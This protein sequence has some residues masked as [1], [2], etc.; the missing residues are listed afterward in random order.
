[1]GITKTSANDVIIHLND[2]I[3]NLKF[4]ERF[5]LRNIIITPVYL[6][7]DLSEKKD[8]LSLD[9]S[10]E[11]KYS[12]KIRDI[13]DI[14]KIEIEN[15]T[16]RN[17]FIMDG[18]QLTGGLQNRMFVHSF[19]LEPRKRNNYN[20]YCIESGRWGGNTRVF[21][22]QRDLSYTRVRLL[23]LINTRTIKKSAQN[24]IWKEIER[25][26]QTLNYYSRTSSLTDLNRYMDKVVEDYIENYEY[27]NENGYLVQHEDNIVSFEILNE[28]SLVKKLYKKMLKS[29]IYDAIGIEEDR[30][31]RIKRLEDETENLSIKRFRQAEKEQEF[32]IFNDRLEGKFYTYRDGLFHLSLFN[33]RKII[34]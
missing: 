18:E 29:Y 23:N 25:K 7:I 10:I 1:M 20:V 12:I 28:N 9:E 11:K 4:G 19:V 5:F 33:N 31:Q 14:N 21:N 15:N 3:K 16:D 6:Q 17:L 34:K 26:S 2:I 24:T 27:S 30:L 22:T 32:H 8:F 13:S